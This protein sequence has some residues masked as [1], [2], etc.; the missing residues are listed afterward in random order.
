MIDFVMHPEI[1]PDAPALA[2]QPED[3][4]R[5]GVAASGGIVARPI[6]PAVRDE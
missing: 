2:R 5:R 4:Q 1:A 3:S 6:P